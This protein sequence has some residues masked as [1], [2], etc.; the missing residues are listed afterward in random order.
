[1]NLCCLAADHAYFIL[2]HNIRIGSL[3]VNEREIQLFHS[4][5]G[6]GRF[7]LNEIVRSDITTS[8]TGRHDVTEAAMW[9]IYVNLKSL[10]R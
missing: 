7:Q 9:E 8:V 6:I 5:L 10:I 3:S 4:P 2:L 1:M